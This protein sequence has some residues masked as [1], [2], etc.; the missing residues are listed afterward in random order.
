MKLLR[1]KEIRPEQARPRLTVAHWA[2]HDLRRTSRTLLAKLGCPDA[3]GETIIGHMLPGVVGT[4]NR[5][6]Y[7]DEK[8]FWLFNLS[9]HLEL[10]AKRFE[11]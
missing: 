4:Y 6:Q 11:R 2:P 1:I 3:V 10:L 5:H 9:E 8:S 7:D